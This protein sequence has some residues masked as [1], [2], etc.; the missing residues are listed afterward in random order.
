M[1][2][3]MTLE[4][5]AQVMIRQSQVPPEVLA[6]AASFFEKDGELALRFDGATLTRAIVERTDN[7]LTA[8]EGAQFSFASGRP[9]VVGGQL[10][11]SLDDKQTRAKIRAAA[12]G[13]ERTATLEVVQQTPENS[14]QALRAMGVEEVVAEFSTPLTSDY[15]RTRNLIRGAEM[16]TGDLI[17]PGETYSLVSALSPITLANGYVSSGMIIGGQ[18]ID[19]VGGGLSQMATTTYNAA[20]IAGF[21]DVEHHPHSYW[22]ERYPAGR[23]ATIAVG[24]KDMKVRNNTPYGA[25][26]QSW[27]ADGRLHVR[28]WSTKHLKNTWTDGPKR[29]IVPAGRVTSSGAGCASYPGGQPGFTI[30]VDRRVERVDDGEVVIERSYTTTYRPD[31]AMSCVAP[32]PPPAP[33]APGGDT[34]PEPPGPDG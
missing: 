27:V 24:S 4:N 25:V 14:T 7:L 17:R 3:M 29:N 13:D 2:M 21:E 22:F 23:E 15:V 32:A 26:M 20:M 10:G 34:A 11:T 12:L 19:G 31:H 9:E 5:G 30:T 16:I 1:I 6:S 28:I 33:P 18:H 8:A